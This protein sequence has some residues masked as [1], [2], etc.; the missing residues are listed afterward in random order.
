MP[1]RE[2][3]FEMKK[4]L[5]TAL[6]GFAGAALFASAANSQWTM[7]S[8]AGDLVLG[9]RI[10]DNIGQGAGFASVGE[11]PTDRGAGNH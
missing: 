6:A 8:A 7:K 1:K 9:F 10:T 11:A 5:T 3:K 2:I 4:L